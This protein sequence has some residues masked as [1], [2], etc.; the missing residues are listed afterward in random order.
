MGENHTNS[1][2]TKRPGE[3][4]AIA[5]LYIA[6]GAT[7]DGDEGIIALLTPMGNMPLI[8][9]SPPALEA[10]LEVAGELANTSGE[11]V[12]VVRFERASV[13]AEFKPGG[14]R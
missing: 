6:L 1:H 14:D 7:A 11:T 13:V 8:C 4:R 2:S 3:P 5:G 12:R 10:I 9:S